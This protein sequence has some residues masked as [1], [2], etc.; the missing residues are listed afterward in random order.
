MLDKLIS[1]FREKNA[2]KLFVKIIAI[3]L[4]FHFV[5]F[6]WIFFRADSLEMAK[7]MINQIFQSFSPGSYVDMLVA[8]KQFFV[9]M[10]AG[11]LI[12]FI[13]EN[14]KEWSRGL[15]ISMPMILKVTVVLVIVVL[16]CAVQLTTPTPFIYFRF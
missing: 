12:H 7:V 9:L 13:P 6:C 14:A 2:K 5:A 8:Y 10:L 4:T 1:P 3:L 11:Y 15:F 16:L